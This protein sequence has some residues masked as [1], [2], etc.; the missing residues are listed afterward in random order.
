MVLLRLTS[1]NLSI[2]LLKIGTVVTYLEQTKLALE[3]YFKSLP[4][5]F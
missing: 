3:F 2:S 4:Y 5:T 1:E